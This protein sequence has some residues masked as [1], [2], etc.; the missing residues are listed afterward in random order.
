MTGGVAHVVAYGATAS[1]CKVSSWNPSGTAMVVNVRCHDTAG[2]LVESP[3]VVFFGKNPSPY[4]AS[5]EAGA[6]L[7]YGGFDVPA[8]W[9]WNSSGG[10]NVVAHTSVGHYTAT[11]QGLK[12]TNAA[13][14]VTAYG[15]GPEYCKVA[16]WNV[17]GI[18]SVVRIRCNNGSGA[19]ADSQ[20]V[21]SFSAESLVPNVAGGHAWISTA[22]TAPADYQYTAGAYATA[23][24]APITVSSFQDVVYDNTA[25][26]SPYA[27][28]ALTTA[29]GDDAVYCKVERWNAPA[30]IDTDVTVHHQCYLPNGT[31]T[32]GSFVSNLIYSTAQAPY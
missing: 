21:V 19:P 31:R 5:N 4:R 30:T 13:V 24:V 14:Q 16:G 18:D 3:F 27:S 9:S 6:D 7:F 17:V 25:L 22:T 12:L 1:R 29:Y 15:D 20:F 23:P 8:A 11:L 26:G 10:A 28:T 32:T 2:A